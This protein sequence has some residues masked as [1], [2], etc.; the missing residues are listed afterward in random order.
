[1]DGLDYMLKNIEKPSGTVHHNTPN[2]KTQFSKFRQINSNNISV[3]SNCIIG[4]KVT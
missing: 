4:I 2:I 3:H 1:M